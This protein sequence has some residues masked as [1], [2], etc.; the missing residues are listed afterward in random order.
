MAFII[1]LKASFIGL[2]F[3]YFRLRIALHCALFLSILKSKT[4]NISE[5][6]PFKPFLLPP[7]L[8]SINSFISSSFLAAFIS[9]KMLVKF[10]YNILNNWSHKH[11]YGHFLATLSHQTFI[12]FP[13]TRLVKSLS[14]IIILLHVTPSAL[15]TTI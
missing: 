11:T 5:C 2:N 9:K 13:H 3:F 10:N 14:I 4:Q 1:I 15:T 6:F 12:L 7:R 8:L